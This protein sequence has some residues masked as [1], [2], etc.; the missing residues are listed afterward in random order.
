MDLRDQLQSTLSHA[1]TIERELGG[2]GMSRVF[3]ANETRLNRRVVVKVLPPELIQGLSA[4]RF[5]REIQLAASLQHANI[6]PVL[7]AGDSDGTPYFTMPYVDG[8]S[9]RVR[10]ARGPLAIAETVSILRDVARALA[11][12]HERGV[13]HRDIKPDNV[14]LSRGAAVV[15]DFGIAKA[16]V[17]SATGGPRGATL[18]QFGTALG[19]PAYMAPEQ[20]AADPNTD[21][22]ADLYAFGCMAYELLVGR[23]PFDARSPQRLLAA[24]MS[25]TPRPVSELRPDTPPE[26]ARLVTRCLE[27]EPD[28]RPRHADELLATLDAVA[29]GDSSQHGAL[30]AILIGGR[31]AA[32][33]AVGLY[34]V[35]FIVVALL[36]KAAIVGI[37]LPDWVFP[38][39]LI[40][41][42]L[43]LPVILFTAYTQH[44][45]RRAAT[46]SP[47]FT[48]GGTPAP[49]THGTMATLA[50]KASPHLS[51]RRTAFGG[52]Y[53]VGGFVILI[54]AFMLL[55][56][57]GIGP[58]G[59]LLARGRFT[60]R[61]P[62]I[63]T[64]FAIQ[65][66]DTALGAV[67]SD[68]VRAGLT[69]SAMISLVPP[70]Q[71]AA[72]LRRMA[73]SPSSRL[74]LATAREMAQREGIKAV[75]DGQVTGVGTGYIVT[76]RL[77]SA[78]SGAELASF[79][80]TGDGPRGLIDASDKLAR[81]L[82]AR[83][84]ESR[85]SGQAT[86]PLAQATTAS[87]EALRLFSLGLRANGN[88]EDPLTAARYARAAVAADSS[89]A[90]AWR[91]LA[92][93]DNNIDMKH[94]EADSAMDRAY[95]LRDRLPE[96]E[97]LHTEAYYFTRGPHQDRSRALTAYMALLERGDSVVAPVNAGEVLRS[98]RVYAR[99]DSL[100]WLVI[101]S[102]AEPG[103]AAGNAIELEL[104]Q[105]NVDAAAK[106]QQYWIERSPT[107][108]G[109]RFHAMFLRYAQHDTAGLARV[110][111][112]LQRSGDPIYQ[113]WGLLGQSAVALLHGRV[114]DGHRLQ[115]ELEATGQR[116]S[117][118]QL[119]DSIAHVT[120][121]AWFN[122]PSPE[123]VR[124]LNTALANH[125]LASLPIVERPYFD[126]AR[127]YAI[128]GD[129]AK[130]AGVIAEYRRGM[131]DTARLRLDAS[132]LHNT[133]GVIAVARGDGKT[134]IDEFRKSDIGYDGQPASECAACI[135][136]ALARGFDAAGQ[137]DS[138][139]AEYEAY[140]AT[141]FW[142][143]LIG[144]DNGSVAFGDELVLAGTEKRLGELYEAKGDRPRA[145]SHYTKFV[146]LWKNAD[147]GLQPKVADVRRRLARLGDTEKR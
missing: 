2:G 84:G 122:G 136:F 118:Q 25:E 14:L 17:A 59:S 47:T 126:A 115:H 113:T 127:A 97:R 128:A 58:A 130:A 57:L 110:L 29:T 64:D 146:E 40:V 125:P 134:A 9:L 129:A 61:E 19:T 1:Y 5:E 13:V 107:A 92:V 116:T 56:E 77:V 90:S 11:Y 6:V 4:E 132:N 8:E 50:L 82:R 102:N 87:L 138:A 67:V 36:A 70:P 112:S 124:A 111:D 10:L 18:T 123:A 96:S 63:I 104:D 41:M 45:A 98:E 21:Y 117:G 44:V 51:W 109:V 95:R 69:Q 119:S 101:R 38:G 78:D 31:G 121:D 143:K 24:H 35:A 23:P 37:G 83:I 142:D 108:H 52:A 105:G 94:A 27:K 60:A 20:A 91:L 68:A 73:R 7:S 106:T 147:P 43:G 54:G 48:P 93:A 28:T 139:I 80:E 16:I 131:T 3:V 33:R 133:L 62:V 135:H 76:L 145:V 42:A 71:V 137:A 86:P 26:L 120:I 39:S 140:I 22:R 99:A 55:R 65:H 49:A 103:I 53:A 66:T 15:T 79:R 89:F 75:I 74:D 141:P 81:E 32:R 72:A 144:S 85:R 88:D 30:P 100:N 46:T 114:A 12:A 34:A